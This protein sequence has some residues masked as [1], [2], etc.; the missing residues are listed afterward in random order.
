MNT[1]QASLPIPPESAAIRTARHFTAE[2]LRA[3]GLETL[4]ETV[5]LLV[6]ELVTN[7][8]LHGGPGAELRLVIDSSGV[9]AEVKDTNV[10]PPAVKHYS[11]LATTGR[12]MLIV[13][14]LAEA[15]GTQVQPD[16]KVV[17][18]EVARPEPASMPLGHA[19]AAN[20]PSHPRSASWFRAL[21]PARKWS[22]G[23]LDPLPAG[24]WW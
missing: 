7:A 5:V 6:S 19:R 21:Q 16:G 8:I 18:F 17:W 13:E 9:R 12:G 11:E 3:H 15:W 20:G 2:F 23:M 4:T 14:S 22:G 24:M 1:N 10:A